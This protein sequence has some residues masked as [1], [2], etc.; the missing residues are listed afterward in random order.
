[1]II[2]RCELDKFRMVMPYEY[3]YVSKRVVEMTINKY[4]IWFVRV[5]MNH[6]K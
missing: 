3:I 5:I 4:L 2:N 6:Q 1:M